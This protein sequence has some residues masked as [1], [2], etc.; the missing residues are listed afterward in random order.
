MAYQMALETA[1]EGNFNT[2]NPKEAVRLIENLASSNNLAFEKK[3]RALCNKRLPNEEKSDM[4]TYKAL[5]S[6]TKEET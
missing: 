6:V 3:I 2:R 5:K 4:Q 1:T